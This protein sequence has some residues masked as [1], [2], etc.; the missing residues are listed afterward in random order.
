M[1]PSF[2]FCHIYI[3]IS[4]CVGKAIVFTIEIEEKHT[5]RSSPDHIESNSSSSVPHACSYAIN[6]DE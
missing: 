6:G 2:R 4:I 1:N 3:S 5:A